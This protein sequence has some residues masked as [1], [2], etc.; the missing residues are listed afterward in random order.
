MSDDIQTT[1]QKE[2]GLQTTTK[3]VPYEGDIYE[4]EAGPEAEY[5]HVGEG[6]A[7]TGA[8]QAL[9]EHLGEGESV[10]S[11]PTKYTTSGESE[12]EEDVDQETDER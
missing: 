6:T 9:L 3:R 10:D 11:A 7:P 12:P 8:V 1:H 2:N 4:F 5:E